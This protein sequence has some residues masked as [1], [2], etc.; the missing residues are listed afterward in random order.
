[1][2]VFLSDVRSLLLLGEALDVFDFSMRDEKVFLLLLCTES[3]I[4]IHALFSEKMEK[5]SVRFH[6]DSEQS[7]RTILIKQWYNILEQ[8][9][10]HKE[11]QTFSDFCYPEWKFLRQ[12]T[13]SM[14][15]N[16]STWMRRIKETRKF[17]FESSFQKS[18]RGSRK[19]RRLRHLNNLEKIAFS[20]W[21]KLADQL[22]YFL[23]SRQVWI[24]INI[25]EIYFKAGRSA[26]VAFSS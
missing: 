26:D 16:H 5:F 13:H 14:E 7:K 17:I 1:M 11:C 8:G 20:N 4:E 9:G 3:F 21:S 12:E 22:F 23:P 6:S 10:I 19:V 18:A 24:S 25:L 15:L 2:R